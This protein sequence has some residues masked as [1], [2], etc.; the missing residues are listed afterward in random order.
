[1]DNKAFT[2]IELL[3]TITI[4][5]LITFMGF[6]SLQKM[7]NDNKKTEFEYYGK[8]IISAAKLYMQK[9]GRDIK[10]LSS[11]LTALKNGTYEV[12]LSDLISGGYLEE[13]HASKKDLSCEIDNGR[14]KIKWDDQ[15]NTTTYNYKLT[16]SDAT[17]LY[18]KKY[19]QED[20]IVKNK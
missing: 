3:V 7:L 9:E 16:C 15:T 6:P 14:V 10:E 18:E 19:D 2:L 5:G 12:L 20:I 4:L 1:M 13:Y 8:S 11:N 17:K